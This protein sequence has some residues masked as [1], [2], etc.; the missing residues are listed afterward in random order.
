M[1]EPTLNWELRR[2]RGFQFYDASLVSQEQ[3]TTRGEQPTTRG[4]WLSALLC[5][6]SCSLDTTSAPIVTLALAR[7]LGYLSDINDSQRG[8]ELALTAVA[9]GVSAW[10]SPR[11][12]RIAVEHQKED[13]SKSEH[14]CCSKH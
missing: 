2:G 12:F 4:M 9:A 5:T 8:I 7:D 13:P 14:K 10:N 11:L 6:I 1:F 3:P